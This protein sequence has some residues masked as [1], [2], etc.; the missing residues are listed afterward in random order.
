MISKR[1]ESIIIVARNLFNKFGYNG[2]SMRNISDEL[3]ISVGNLTYH[4]KKKE[5]LI[6][7]VVQYKHK[8]YRKMDIPNNVEELEQIFKFVL[9]MRNENAYYF[10]HYFQ[11]SL[12]SEEIYNLQMKSL[13][14]LQDSLY[15]GFIAL[16]NHEILISGISNTQIAFLVECI[17]SIIIYRPVNTIGFNEDKTIE[18][19]LSCLWSIVN[20]YLRKEYRKIL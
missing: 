17:L 9:D 3:G 1:K 16:R 2:V 14:D 5:D 12:I 4:Y 8:N 19:I 13:S 6:E 7:A 20:M 11:L 15:K 10:N 18:N